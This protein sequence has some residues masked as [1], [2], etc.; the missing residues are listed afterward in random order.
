M[1][2]ANADLGK[3]CF[4]GSWS[5]RVGRLFSRYLHGPNQLQP[6]LWLIPAVLPRVDVD[7]GKPPIS[8]NTDADDHVT[9]YRRA[10]KAILKSRECE[11]LRR[12]T[13]TY[14][15][16]S[17]TEKTSDTPVIDTLLPRLKSVENVRG[18]YADT[19]DEKDRCNSFEHGATP[20]FRVRMPVAPVHSQKYSATFQIL[21]WQ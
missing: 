4:R 10:A 16:R 6:S 12:R 18:K 9:A 21:S 2:V 19:Q 11:G 3:C 7:R 1:R 17:F 14:R 15:S 5:C 20:G 13:T 8:P